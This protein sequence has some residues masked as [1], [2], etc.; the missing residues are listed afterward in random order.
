MTETHKGEKLA[1]PIIFFSVVS[2]LRPSVGHGMTCGRKQDVDISS[3]R[4]TP[5]QD[6]F[7]KRDFL[8]SVSIVSEECPNNVLVVS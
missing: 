5:T 8:N 1:H 4:C 6:V 3:D 2:A 7:L